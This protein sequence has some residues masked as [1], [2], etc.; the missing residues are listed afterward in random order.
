MHLL[1]GTWKMGLTKGQETN[2]TTSI[3]CGYVD[4]LPHQMI[5][6]G[7]INANVFTS[8]EQYWNHVEPLLVGLLV[9]DSPSRVMTEGA[10]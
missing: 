4:W 10:Y 2:K 3:G 5:M 8:I 9:L 1:W 7:G 6:H